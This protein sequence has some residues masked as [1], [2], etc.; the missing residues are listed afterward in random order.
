MTP[1]EQT[2]H[3]LYTLFSQALA[4]QNKERYHEELWRSYGHVATP[5]GARRRVQFVYDLCRLARFDPQDKVILDAGCGYGVIAI[6]LSLMG[7]RKV[8]G[9]D[10]SE[11]RLT[12]FQRMIQVEAVNA[13]TVYNL[14]E[15]LSTSPVLT[16]ALRRMLK[17]YNRFQAQDVV[18]LCFWQAC[19]VTVTWVEPTGG[20]EPP[21]YA[22]RVR[23]STD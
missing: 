19:R 11:E 13:V 21:T 10:I 12:T 14:C 8:W 6:I 4:S 18:R 2:T 3:Q 15:L 17:S 5:S 22:L 16:Y 20:L 23:R 1:I 7:T 9:I